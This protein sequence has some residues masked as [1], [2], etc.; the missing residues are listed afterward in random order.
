M[1]KMYEKTLKPKKIDMKNAQSIVERLSDFFVAHHH[2]H[3]HFFVW[4]LSGALSL[5]SNKY[6]IEFSHN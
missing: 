3:L 2:H 4:A 1:F 5:S 6:D